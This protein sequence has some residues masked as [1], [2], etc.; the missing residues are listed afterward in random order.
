MEIRKTACGASATSAGVCAECG[1]DARVCDW[2]TGADVRAEDH[3]VHW[4]RAE[5]LWELVGCPGQQ[6]LFLEGQYQAA[7]DDV[8]PW[9]HS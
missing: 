3:T 1:R 7:A 4:Q 9:T 8:L 5:Q 6:A 2:A